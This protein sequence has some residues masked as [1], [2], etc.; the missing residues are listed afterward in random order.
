MTKVKKEKINI[1]DQDVNRF[2]EYIYNKKDSYS[3]VVARQRQFDEI[4]KTLN[5]FFD[6]NIAILDVGCGDGTFT[7]KIFDSFKPRNIF[8]VDYSKKG[9]DV[10]TKKV[11][12]TQKKRIKFKYIDIYEI[13]KKI[14][15]YKYDVALLSGVLHHLDRAEV[16]VY[17]LSKVVDNIIVI[18]PNGYNPILKIIENVSSYH[19]IH[20]EKSYLPPT[21]DKWFIKRG[22]KVKRK[23]YFG[24]VPYFCIEIIAKIL[25]KIE[26]IIE[27][28]PIVKN[29]LCGSSVIFYSK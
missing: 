4:L 2:G 24:L 17:K 27:N 8:G 13:D 1:Y 21:L 9:I 15:K 28:I 6:Q 10:A 20:N 26:P 22:Y 18:E 29:I 19:I 25:K 14:K 5:L 16:I 23:K 7:I 3:S 11:K 12:K